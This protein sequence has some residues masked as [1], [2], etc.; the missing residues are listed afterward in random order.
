MLYAV[1]PRSSEITGVRREND[2]LILESENM[3]YAL[4][5]VSEG[6]IRAV[7]TREKA[8]SDIEKPG[9]CNN[10]VF[11]DWKYS[12]TQEE[13]VLETAE[14]R[15]LICRATG[16]FSWHDKTGRLL[17]SETEKDPK[18]LERY[19]K[20]RTVSARTERVKTADGEKEVVR[21]AERIEDGCS[22]HATLNLKFQDG[23]AI[24]G[25]GQHEEGYGNLRGKTLYLNQANRKIVIP[26]AIS[27][28]GYGILVDTY[29]P[30]IYSDGEFSTYIYS[31]SVPEL[32]YYFV[33]GKDMA[34]AVRGYRYLTGNAAMLPKWAFG[35]IQSQ[36]RYETQEEIEEIVT[37]Y[38]EKGIGIDCAVLDWCSWEDGKWGQKSFDKK[39]FPDPAGMVE[40][41]HE[42]N[43]HFMISV[44]ANSD[45]GGEN[46]EE[47][48]KAGLFLPGQNIYNALSE[49]GR[50]MYWDQLSKGLFKYGVDAWWCDNSEPITPEWNHLERPEPSRMYDE[51]CR[52]VS[53]HIPDEFTNSFGLYHAM[54]VYEGQRKETEEK[55]VC[56]LTRSGYT[57]SQRYGTILW[58]GDIAA[59]WDTLTEQIATGLNFSAAGHPYWTTD[60]G[61]FFVKRSVNWYWRGDFD[62]TVNDLGYRELFTRWYQW[63]AFLPIFRGHG[64]DCRRELW[65]YENAEDVKFYD[66]ILKANRLRYKLMPYIYSVAADCCLNGASMIEN[67]AFIAPTDPI[68]VEIKDQYMFG[69]AMMICPVHEPMYYL[70]GSVKTDREKTRRVYLPETPGG[71]YAFESG[72]HYNGGQWITVPAPI[73]TVPVFVRAGSVIPMA[74]HAL[75]VGEQD[76]GITVGKYPG[77]DGKFVLYEDSGDGYGYEKGE[78]RLTEIVYD[79]S[80]GNL[81]YKVIHDTECDFKKYVP[82]I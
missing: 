67:L 24:Y 78:Y 60:I 73:D 37:K 62:G 58:S 54:G 2:T 14:I 53:N 71:W 69:P 46:H 21:D 1:K 27:N 5:P 49:E 64:T 68:A 42:M 31:E 48:K 77:A 29:S 25:L 9:V 4:K 22:Y 44:W 23:E 47:F 8:F 38:R 34:G 43:A 36:E 63:E 56:N 6:I 51:Y 15:L 75:S 17:L 50:R 12:E 65:L 35:Y 72:E 74:K 32:D 16:S 82:E 7:A 13:I 26:Y 41:L 39:R 76:P 18:I 40:K 55:R 19:T 28:L 66:A 45:P 3:L 61:A 30:L 59:T 10:A 80:T 57:G 52:S 20:Y 33:Y 70:P 79:N 81:E 11:S